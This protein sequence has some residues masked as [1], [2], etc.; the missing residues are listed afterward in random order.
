MIKFIDEI[1]SE[2][3]IENEIPI[4]VSEYKVI[5]KSAFGPKYFK[6]KETLV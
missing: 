3:Q 6:N 4:R 2:W 1:V 5:N